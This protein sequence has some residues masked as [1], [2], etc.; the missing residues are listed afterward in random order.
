MVLCGVDI[1][2][3]FLEMNFGN[4]ILLLLGLS[5]PLIGKLIVHMVVALA[6]QSIQAE[7][8]VTFVTFV[9]VCS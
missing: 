4:K 8:F 5:A 3:I 9:T 1:F 2:Q 6:S 7:K